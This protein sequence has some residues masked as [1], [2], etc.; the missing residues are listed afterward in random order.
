MRSYVVQEL[1][2]TS[3]FV[4]LNK[5]KGGILKAAQPFVYHLKSPSDSLENH[6]KHARMTTF[7][8]SH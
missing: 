5:E 4:L 2:T 1:L 3:L 8:N 7:N 6:K